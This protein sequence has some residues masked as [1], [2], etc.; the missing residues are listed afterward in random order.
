MK[1]PMLS[2]AHAIFCE[3][4]DEVRNA[5]CSLF[6]L[7]FWIIKNGL[8]AAHQKLSKYYYQFDLSPFYVWAACE[9]YNYVS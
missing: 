6:D 3:L 8:L 1:Q 4:Q 2:T 9:S 7:T 5:L